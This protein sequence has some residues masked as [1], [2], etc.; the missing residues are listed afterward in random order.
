M[1]NDA[2]Q[3]D[4]E[5]QLEVHVLLVLFLRQEKNDNPFCSPPAVIRRMKVGQGSESQEGSSSMTNDAK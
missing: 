3:N 1:T 5:L 2:K 4:Y